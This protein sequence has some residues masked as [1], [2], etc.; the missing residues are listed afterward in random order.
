MNSDT[1]PALARLGGL[2][3]RLSAAFAIA[4]GILLLGVTLI[5]VISV[6]GRGLLSRPILGDFELVQIGCAV[7]V[8]AFLPY[9]QMRRGNVFVGFLTQRAPVAMRAGLDAAADAAYALIAGIITWRLALG[10]ADFAS[11]G[12]VSMVLRLPLWW[13]FVPILA[14]MALLSVVA[15]YSAWASLAG[16]HR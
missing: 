13:G 1:A 10:A 8:F 11:S 7:A 14:S 6:A 12:E 5:T 2:L 4:G 9:C 16:E 15:A 3:T